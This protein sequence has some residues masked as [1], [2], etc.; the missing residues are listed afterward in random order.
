MHF[1][2]RMLYDAAVKKECTHSQPFLPNARRHMF[3]S[4][5]VC[6]HTHIGSEEKSRFSFLCSYLVLFFLNSFELFLR[7]FQ[8]G[9]NLPS[10]EP[11]SALIGRSSNCI[12]NMGLGY[13]SISRGSVQVLLASGHWIALGRSMVKWQVASG[14]FMGVYLSHFFSN[15]SI[16]FRKHLDSDFWGMLKPY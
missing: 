7:H 3:F 2:E 4:I 9:C 10:F 8:S 11:S 5:P 16:F 14:S 6:H 15:V 13:V 1:T 12:C